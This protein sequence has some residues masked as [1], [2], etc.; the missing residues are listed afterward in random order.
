MRRSISSADWVYFLV[1]AAWVVVSRVPYLN[2]DEALG[3]DGPLYIRSLKLDATY[4]VPMP[5][6]IGY[7]LLGKLAFQLTTDPVS[8]FLAV[9]IALTA[10]GAIFTYLFAV[11]IVSRP[12][13]AALT[14]A[15][16]CNPLVWYHG[17]IIASYPVWLAV[18][19]AIGW[20]GLRYKRE[21]QLGDLV[22]VS[23]ALGVGTILRPDL[24]SF[25][26]PLW[27][28][29]LLLGRAPWKHWLIGGSIVVL[30]CCGWFFGTAWVLG[31]VRVYLARVQAKHVRDAAGF[32]VFHQG[33]IEGL[34]RNGVKYALFLVWG[35]QLVLIPF[36]WGLGRVLIAWKGRWKGLLL[37]MLWIG[38]SWYFSFAIFTGNAGLVFPFLPL[39]YL[40][41]AQGLHDWLGGSAGWRA[42]TAMTL[43][44]L[45]SV[46][47]FTQLPLRTETN[48]RDV[49]LNVT[50]LRYTGAGLLGHYG[51]NLDDYGVSP[52]LASVTRQMGTPEAIPHLAAGRLQPPK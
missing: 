41:A 25:G 23:V 39:L 18:L 17:G 14:F 32:S 6:N 30:A 12:M 46:A 35:A 20:F 8:A 22:G 52:S 29:F 49:I 4:D 11:M 3:K 27:F 42:V 2:T 28:G 26:A 43:L 51:F 44:G 48:Q 16:T 50:F 24:I 15:L 33:F 31:G 36:V 34:L 9:N 5:G 38:P 13:A 21:G 10:L 37:A 1:L 45:L 19:P 47:Q 7:V 40:G